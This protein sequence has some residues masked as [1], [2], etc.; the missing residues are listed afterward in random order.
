MD[1]LANR[2]HAAVKSLWRSLETD[3]CREV[4]DYLTGP[5]LFMLNYIHTERKCNL[6]QLA[7]RLEVKP[8]AVTVMVDRLEKA[9]YV[10][11]SSDPA[12]R[13]VILVG[14]TPMGAEVLAQAVQKRNMCLKEHMSRLEPEEVRIVTELCEKMVVPKQQD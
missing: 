4:Q 11:R 3:V 8:S 1:A 12:D 7:D 13:R 14:A 6:T 10:A 9:G 5:Q 2:L